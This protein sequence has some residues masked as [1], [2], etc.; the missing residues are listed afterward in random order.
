M[1]KV[2]NLRQ[3]SFSGKSPKPTPPRKPKNADVWSRAYLT[4]AAAGKV[5]Q[6]GHQDKTLI[7]TLFRHGLRVSELIALHWNQMALDAGLVH[8]DRRKSGTPALIPWEAQRSG[9]CAG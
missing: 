1:S 6:H 2:V 3:P 8:I 9:R 4:L 5:G 7:L